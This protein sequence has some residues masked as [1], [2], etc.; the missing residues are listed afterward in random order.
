MNQNCQNHLVV[1]PQYL[2][3]VSLVL[4]HQS[5]IK[6]SFSSDAGTSISFDCP[7]VVA[8]VPSLVDSGVCVLA[9]FLKRLNPM[10]QFSMIAS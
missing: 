3:K 9:S 8:S 6:L 1:P 2:V 7:G 4:S 10:C 5:Q